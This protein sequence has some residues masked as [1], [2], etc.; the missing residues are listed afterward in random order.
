MMHASFGGSVMS[1]TTFAAPNRARFLVLTFRPVLLMLVMGAF[2]CL[3]G[4]TAEVKRYNTTGYATF[5]IGVCQHRVTNVSVAGG[6]SADVWRGLAVGADLGFFRF[7][8]RNSSAFGIGTANLGYRYVNRKKP[9]KF[10]PFVDT[11]L[12]LAF[13]GG[14]AAS[15]LSAGAGTYYWLKDRVGLRTEGRVYVI[16]RSEAIVMVRVGISFR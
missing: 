10:E 8:E 2:A 12:G 15:A 14:E 9:G 4:Q 5:G 3:A 16:A 13:A 1:Q 6:G 7:V 11:G